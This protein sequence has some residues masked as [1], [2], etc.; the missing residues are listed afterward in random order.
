MQLVLPTPPWGFCSLTP[1]LLQEAAVSGP[2]ETMV[3]WLL[4]C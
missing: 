3:L 2:Q 1:E 4:L